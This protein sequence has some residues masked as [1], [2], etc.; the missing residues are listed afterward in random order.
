[1]TSELGNEAGARGRVL[2]PLWHPG[3]KV[4]DGQGRA[5]KDPGPQDTHHSLAHTFHCITVGRVF[6][7][8]PVEPRVYGFQQCTYIHMYYIQT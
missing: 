2:H 5:F 7:H 6:A 8:P 4:R 1:M 3:H